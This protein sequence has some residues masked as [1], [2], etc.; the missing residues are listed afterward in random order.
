MKMSEKRLE[1]SPVSRGYSPK[2]GRSRGEPKFAIVFKDLNIDDCCEGREYV[3]Y[4]PYG[5]LEGWALRSPEGLSFHRDV[6]DVLDY[7][8][9]D[10]KVIL[11]SRLELLE[12]RG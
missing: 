2:E 8:L 4:P 1:G 7:I 9:R 3:I 5:E 6:R 10:V 11:E 12:A